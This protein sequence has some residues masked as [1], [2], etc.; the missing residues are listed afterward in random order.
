MAV[1]TLALGRPEE[2]EPDSCKIPDNNESV[3]AANGP[4]L[5]VK[6]IKSPHNQFPPLPFSYL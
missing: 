4:E 1:Y 5:R 3:A 6:D 2:L